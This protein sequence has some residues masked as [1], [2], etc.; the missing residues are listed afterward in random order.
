MR[1]VLATACLMLS[2]LFALAEEPAPPWLR[3]GPH[4]TYD[5]VTDDLVTGGLG[6]DAMRGKRPGYA[7]PL[8]PTAV[9]LRRAALF[10]PGSAGQGFGRLFGPDVDETT[11]KKLDG[12]GK[13]AGEEYLAYADNGEGKQNVAM[14]LQIPANLSNEQRCLVALP[15]NGSSSLFRDVVDFG[16]WGLRRGCAVVYTD[17]GHGNG[18][19]I[20][21]QDLVNVLDGRQVPAAEAGRDAHFRADLD[22]A[23]RAKF[24]SE[25]PHRIA[26]K[27]AHS[28][29][30]PEKD[31]GEDLLKAIRFAFWQL[32]Q[33]D[34]EL[35][36]REHVGHRDG[37]LERRR[38]RPLR[39]RAGRG[40]RR[41][42][43]R[44]R[45]RP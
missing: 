24:L 33:R 23:A 29:Q 16:F 32:G 35:H 19:D 42:P 38:G 11:G 34:P 12:Q 13:I 5:G 36:P 28:K 31:W 2:V 44:R 10:F 6:A 30:N 4:T 8:H 9:E 41:T 43:D 37:K 21:E 18:F 26:F 7:D 25:W 14:L 20:L 15:V 39:G 3:V 17:K 27:A 22:D 1:T 40:L 45:R